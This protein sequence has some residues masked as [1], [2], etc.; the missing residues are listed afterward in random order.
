MTGEQ[1]DVW[2]DAARAGGTWA[3]GHLWESLSP[4]V[5]GYVRGRGVPDP[6]D[7]TSEVFLAAFQRLDSFEG[8]GAQ[9]RAWLFTIAHHKAVDAVRRGPAVREQLMEAVDDDRPVASAETAALDRLGDDAVRELLDQLTDEQREVV[10]LRVVGELSL[11]ETAQ[12]VGR[13][14]GSVKQLQRRGLAR[15]RKN[16]SSPAVTSAPPAA[17]AWVR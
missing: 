7:T 8:D 11:A 12:V 16:L 10:L 5:H 17:I 6:D 9:F 3:F 14:V 13:P 2:V 4:T 15:L 1:L